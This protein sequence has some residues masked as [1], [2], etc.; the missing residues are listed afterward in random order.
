MTDF[1][2]SR[3]NFQDYQQGREGYRRFAWEGAILQ[4]P[5]RKAVLRGRVEQEG[6]GC[7]V[8]EAWDRKQASG[9]GPRDRLL[10]AGQVPHLDQGEDPRKAV[11]RED[12]ARVHEQ[13]LCHSRAH[14]TAGAACMRPAAGVGG[15]CAGVQPQRLA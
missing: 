15:V 1:S 3:F 10:V 6:L 5:E 4:V 7:V 2:D 11:Q 8:L 13:L 9:E 12:G 14:F